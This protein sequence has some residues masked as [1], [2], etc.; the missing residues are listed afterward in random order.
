M[1][2]DADSQIDSDESVVP[3][4]FR[5]RE[6]LPELL[7]R[8]T[9]TACLTCL[10]V[11]TILFGF[12]FQH[13]VD[14][15]RRGT[16]PTNA[17]YRADVNH[18]MVFGEIALVVTWASMLLWSATAVNNARRVAPILRS[19]WTA[20]AGWLL[21]PLV[22]LAAHQFL[23]KALESGWVFGGTALFVLLYA[24]HATV[25]GAAKDLGGSTYFARTWYVLILLGA[26]VVTAALAGVSSGLPASSPLA[27]LQE[28]AFLCVVGGLLVLAGAA[29]FYATARHLGE[30]VHHRWALA[31]VPRG[32][33][34]AP[35][36]VVSVRRSATFVHKR[37]IPTLGLRIVIGATLIG[38]NVGGVGAILVTRRRALVA[39]GA[40]E[41][42]ANAAVA[43]ANRAFDHSLWLIAAVH[44]V[45][46]AW[47][48]CAA[49]N[50]RR[51][52]LMATSSLVIATA[53]LA[54][55]APIALAVRA[56]SPFGTTAVAIAAVCV[57]YIAG[58]LLLGRSAVALGGS[59]RL[60]QYWLMAQAVFGG[61]FAYVGHFV[62]TEQQLV[63]VGVVLGMCAVL[64]S[65]LCWV[66]MARF[67]RLCQAV[68][69]SPRRA[70][71]ASRADALTSSHSPSSTAR[72]AAPI[73]IPRSDANASTLSNR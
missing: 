32:S 56:G 36:G 35:Q 53:F 5:A 52:T 18:L 28:K 45:Y 41:A 50:A 58:Q 64:T 9:A 37:P 17:S 15:Y 2:T 3:L 14:L 65:V 34:F 11:L 20:A 1:T 51:R 59:G 42:A 19:G 68:P 67:D 73:S 44:A 62:R 33:T 13:N 26:V 16:P 7:Q 55:V 30:L 24:P 6:P 61:C 8:W 12:L 25:A 39:G 63:S 71:Q 40:D 69:A 23:D 49:V 29:G 72:S 27:S 47:A 38:A 43:S 48:I 21:V 4:A 10:G 70:H 57:G 54:A 22:A 60:F 31:L 46:V 66:A